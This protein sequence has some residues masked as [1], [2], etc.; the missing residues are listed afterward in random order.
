MPT[1]RTPIIRTRRPSGCSPEAIDLFVALE[2]LPSRRRYPDPRSKK[3]AELLGLMDEY[4]TVNHV[5]DTNGPPIRT[6]AQRDWATCQAVREQLLE[7][8]HADHRV[9]AYN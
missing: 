6:I 5:N 2:K 7:A 8:S 1:N 4:W 3:L 9:V